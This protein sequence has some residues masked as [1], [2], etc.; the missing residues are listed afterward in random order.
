[1]AEV[2]EPDK[3]IFFLAK[4]FISSQKHIPKPPHFL[5]IE[6]FYFYP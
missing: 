1:M 5:Q 6:Y 4:T 2:V 3:T